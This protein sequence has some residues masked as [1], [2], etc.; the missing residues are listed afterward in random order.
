MCRRNYDYL[1]IP[2]TETIFYRHF[3]IQFVKQLKNKT[4]IPLKENKAPQRTSCIYTRNHLFGIH[5]NNFLISF[6]RTFEKHPVTNR[7][8]FI[9]E[10]FKN[11]F[12]KMKNIET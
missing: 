5:L 8:K 12:K 4:Q 9:S 1:V 2:V 3:C 6:M 10:F 11:Y 7:E